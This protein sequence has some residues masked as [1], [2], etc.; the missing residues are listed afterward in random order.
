MYK[1]VIFYSYHLAVVS[2]IEKVL[3]VGRMIFVV[4]II[5]VIYLCVLVISQIRFRIDKFSTLFS[6]VA[7]NRKSVHEM[8]SVGKEISRGGVESR[9]TVPPH[10]IVHQDVC[11]FITSFSML[12]RKTDFAVNS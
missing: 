12:N 6:S 8:Y 11:L 5:I 4:T 3:V 1:P 7:T 10:A 9:Y 2:S